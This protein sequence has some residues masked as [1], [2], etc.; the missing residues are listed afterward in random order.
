[1]PAQA[2]HRDVHQAGC[3]SSRGVVIRL[4]GAPCRVSRFVRC[5]AG[6]HLPVHRNLALIPESPSGLAMWRWEQGPGCDHAGFARLPCAQGREA[7]L[8]VGS[9]LIDG[10]GRRFNRAPQLA[11]EPGAH[12]GALP[13]QVCG[14]VGGVTTSGAVRRRSAAASVVAAR[15]SEFEVSVVHR[16][17]ELGRLAPPI[18]AGGPILADSGL[19]SGDAALIVGACAVGMVAK[20]PSRPAGG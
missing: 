17:S 19:G 8:S 6:A 11:R 9:A 16:R 5:S 3:S 12:R 7:R 20:L 14:I 10:L 15:S 1:M 2:C 13:A 4:W 18:L